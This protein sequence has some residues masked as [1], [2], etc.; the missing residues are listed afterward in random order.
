MKYGD[1]TLTKKKRTIISALL[2]LVFVIVVCAS[3]IW[4]VSPSGKTITMIYEEEGYAIRFEMINAM[5]CRIIPLPSEIRSRN[6]PE[7]FHIP[8]T[9]PNGA[10]VRASSIMS[11]SLSSTF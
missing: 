3:I 5:N 9:A 6:Y 7:E 11:T 2:S 4:Y 1:N 10:K 8:S